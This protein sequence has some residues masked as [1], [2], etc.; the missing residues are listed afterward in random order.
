MTDSTQTE[1]RDLSGPEIVSLAFDA[2]EK[3]QSD[4]EDWLDGVDIIRQT[5]MYHDW[6][7]WE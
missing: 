1:R 2:F 5:E 7:M 6:A 4:N 3:W